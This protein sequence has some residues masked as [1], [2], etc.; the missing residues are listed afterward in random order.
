MS[1]VSLL[2][3]GCATHPVTVEIE[4]RPADPRGHIST[5][6]GRPGVVVAAPHGTSDSRTGEIASEIARRTGF[7]LVVA[8][9]FTLETGADGRPLRRYQVNRP[10]EGRPG[11]SPAHDQ[12]TPAARQIYEEY[13]RRVREAARGPL[14]FYVEIHGNGRE[15]NAGRIE[16]ATAGVDRDH[17]LQLRT[18][19]EL[20]RDAHLRGQPEAPRLAILV[21]PADAV[22]YAAGGAK[23][24]GI[25]QVP[26][27]A[28][29]IELPRAA[30]REFREIYTTILAEFLAEAVAL[31]P[32]PA[33][34]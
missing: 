5:R 18:L 10:S 32:L 29:H 9:G 30:R 15:E 25:L 11:F 26:E 28:L 16:I 13:E 21:E 14:R 20:T 31:R 7:A 4:P 3:Y 24:D 6:P 22:F 33:G 34:R 27:R 2:V 1:I 8:T 19:L 17:A 12:A 23:R